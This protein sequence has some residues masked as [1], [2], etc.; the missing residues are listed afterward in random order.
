MRIISGRYKGHKI[1]GYNI[2]GTRP[3]MDRVKESLIAMIQNEIPDSVCLDLFT[4]SGSVGLELLSNGAKKCYFVDNNP[5]VIETLTRNIKKL[6]V[7]EEYQLLKGNFE[8]V[9]KQLA[10]DNVKLDIVFLDP[11]YKDNYISKAIKLI[12]EYDLLNDE[13]LIICEYEIEKI[14]T[15]DYKIIKEKRYGSK[16]VMILKMDKQN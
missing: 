4:G 9:L 12:K 13:G 16:W 14:D 1:D 15:L 6:N 5:K 2:D 8:N 7:I 3:T 10:K 11:P